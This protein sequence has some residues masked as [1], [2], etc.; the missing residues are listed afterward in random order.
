MKHH[1]T[2]M[3]R[4]LRLVNEIFAGYQVTAAFKGRVVGMVAHEIERAADIAEKVWDFGLNGAHGGEQANFTARAIRHQPRIISEAT[5][6]KAIRPKR[7][8]SAHTS[9]KDGSHD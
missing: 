2:S 9:H 1:E 8:R 5:L 3:Q 4:A 6:A 7:R